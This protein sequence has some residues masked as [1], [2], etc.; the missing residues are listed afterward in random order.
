MAN[1]K[2]YFNFG[3]FRKGLYDA[4]L[5]ERARLVYIH[6]LQKSSNKGCAENALYNEIELT[7]ELIAIDLGILTKTN[8]PSTKLIQRALEELEKHGYITRFQKFKSKGCPLTIRLNLSQQFLKENNTQIE[9]SEKENETSFDKSESGFV[10]HYNPYQSLLIHSNP[11][12]SSTI[13]SNEKKEELEI[14]QEPTDEE[15]HEDVFLNYWKEEF[16]KCDNKEALKKDFI[17]TAKPFVEK[18]LLD[19]TQEKI[20]YVFQITVA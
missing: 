12:Q 16:K 7:K 14:V 15:F 6:L 13:S 10:H 18:G 8:E 9:K 11:L 4:N 17:E 20:D 2:N 19:I 3:A 5:S 1:K